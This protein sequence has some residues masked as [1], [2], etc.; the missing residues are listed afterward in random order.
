MNK[1]QTLLEK[2]QQIRDLTG[3]NAQLCDEISFLKERLAWLERQVFGQKRERF[4]PAD[5]NQLEIEL[6][7]EKIEAP[8]AETEQISYERKK[9]K[10]L[11]KP[12]G[13]QPWPADLPRVVI[14]LYPEVDDLDNYVILGY[15]I[16]EELECQPE[17]LYVRQ[18]RRPRLLRKPEVVAQDQTPKPKF[19]AARP[20]PRPLPKLSVGMYLLAR[21]ICDKFLDHLP[22]HRQI[23]RF[24]RLGVKLAKAT[25]SGWVMA[26]CEL[27]EPLF[28]ANRR[29]VLSAAYLQVD[30]TRI[31]VLDPL[32]ARPKHSGKKAKAPPPGKSHRGYYWVYC[33]PIRGLALF[34]Y[35]PGRGGQYPHATLDGFRGSLQTDGYAVYEA[36]DKRPGIT[37]L[38]CLAHVRRKFFEAQTGSYPNE[39]QTALRLIRLLYAIEEW[40]KEGM[41]Q[42]PS[43]EAAVQLRY[44]LRQR[45]AKPLVHAAKEWLQQQAK[46]PRVL[47]Q[48]SFGKAVNHA[49]KRFP[50][51]ERYLHDGSVEIDSNWV[52][53]KIRPLALGRKNYLFAG[54]EQA[55]I[56]AGNLYALLA[57]AKV[58]GLKPVE[59]L[60]DLLETIPNHPVNRIEELLPH[61][62]KPNPHLPPWLDWKPGEHAPEPDARLP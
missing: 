20:L 19:L 14:D 21:I 56:N 1:G 31:Q 10:P 15:E 22:L 4:I 18:L 32:K 23:Q 2:D 5:P 50:Y 38:G 59:Y 16:T 17:K 36:F 28:E 37:L 6:G 58:Q 24:E 46:D 25:V 42:A 54:S 51:I 61:R 39:V 26:V 55:A 49:L 11:A 13:R 34:D 44:E 48:S 47:P 3:R 29:L 40:A 35:H 12:S 45:R 27:L 9:K 60:R 30:E 53:N 57:A 52:E 41:E 62:W 43:P 33:D 7:V 8:A